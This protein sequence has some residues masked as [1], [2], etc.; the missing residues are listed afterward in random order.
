MTHSNDFSQPH[1]Y[2]RDD[3]FTRELSSVR[4]DVMHKLQLKQQ[5]A[6]EQ[7]R[8][9][10]ASPELL[11]QLEQIAFVDETTGFATRA[12]VERKLE[13]ETRRAK[14]YRR[15]LAILA[16]KIDQQEELEKQ[17]SH[18][19]VR[20]LFSMLRDVI[21]DSIRDV[22]IPG[23]PSPGVITVLCPE[24]NMDGALVLAQRV[25]RKLYDLK[26]TPILGNLR[27]TA[28]VGISVLPKCSSTAE[29]LIQ[30]AIES[31]NKGMRAGGNRIVRKRIEPVLQDYAS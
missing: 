30:S 6:T 10:N 2:T 9:R 24:T 1:G 15:P 23:R 12:A 25:M 16:I 5:L 11:D 27:L 19:V 13:Y 26:P 31:A 29:D 14:R 17:L 21:C 7:A 20:D 28:T 3:Q 22:D 18:M 8:Y 4:A